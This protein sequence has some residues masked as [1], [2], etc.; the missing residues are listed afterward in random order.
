M[1]KSEHNKVFG[2]FKKIVHR[3]IANYSADAN[4]F[5]FS[6]TD[7]QKLDQYQ[8]PGNAIYTHIGCLTTF[9]G[10]DIYI[11]DYCN[12]H[13]N[14]FTNLGYSFKPPNDLAYGSNE[15]KNYL[16]GSYNFSVLEHEVYTLTFD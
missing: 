1:V 13:K 3:V 4:A 2:G 10:H 8:N 11:S 7:L 5:I 14:S 12:A 15:A 16:A 9:G 6:L